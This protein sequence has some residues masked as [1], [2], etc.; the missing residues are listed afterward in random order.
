MSFQDSASYRSSTLE[1]I[2]NDCSI[3]EGETEFNVCS[4]ALP[5]L[6][7]GETENQVTPDLPRPQPTS[8]CETTPA[9]QLTLATAP[10]ETDSRAENPLTSQQMEVQDMFFPLRPLVPDS[11]GP[12]FEDNWAKAFG[13]SF[14]HGGD[15]TKVT[16]HYPPPSHSFL[17]VMGWGPVTDQV[18]RLLR[19]QPD[20]YGKLKNLRDKDL[21]AAHSNLIAAMGPILE[22]TVLLGGAT[23]PP[24][25]A[26]VQSLSATGFT[27]GKAAFDLVRT[28][29]KNILD[30]FPWKAVASSEWKELADN[31]A[32]SPATGNDLFTKEMLEKIVDFVKTLVEHKKRDSEL[33]RLLPSSYSSGKQ[34]RVRP[35]STRGAHKRPPTSP[36]TQ[37][38]KKPRRAPPQH[39]KP[40]QGR[41][42]DA[43]SSKKR[44]S[45]RD[46]SGPANRCVKGVYT[47]LAT[48][49]NRPGGT[50]Q[51][52]IRTETAFL[53]N[54]DKT[55]RLATQ[56]HTDKLGSRG[57]QA[58]RRVH[59]FGSSCG[60][61]IQKKPVHFS[62][63]PDGKKPSRL[64][65]HPKPKKVERLST[66]PKVQNGKLC[67]SSRPHPSGLLDG[68]I[69]SKRRLL[70]RENISGPS[71]VPVLRLEGKVLLLP[72]HAK[73]PKSGSTRVHENPKAGHGIYKST[74]HKSLYLSG[75]LPP[76]R[77]QL[78]EPIGGLGVYKVPIDRPGFHHKRQKILK[79]PDSKT[80]IFGFRDRLQ[81]SDLVSPTRQTPG[82]PRD[83]P[84]PPSG[85]HTGVGKTAGPPD[86]VI[87][88]GGSGYTDRK[89]PLQ[90]NAAAKTYGINVQK[91]LHS[92]H[93]APHH[94][95]GGATVVGKI[96]SRRKTRAD[97][98]RS[99]CPY[100]YLYRQLTVYVGRFLKRRRHSRHLDSKGDSSPHK[101]ARNSS[102]PKSVEP[103][104][105]EYTGSIPGSV[106]RQQNG[107]SLHS[108]NGG[109]EKHSTQPDLPRNMEGSSETRLIPDSK[110]HSVR[111]K[112]GGRPVVSQTAPKEG[113]V[114]EHRGIQII[115]QTLGHPRGRFVCDQHQRESVQV[116]V[117]GTRPEGHGTERSGGGN[118]VASGQDCICIP[119][120]PTSIEDSSKTRPVESRKPHSD[121]T[122]VENTD[123]LP[124]N[125]GAAGRLPA[126]SP[127]SEQH[128]SRPGGE[129]SPAA[130]SR[131]PELE[132]LEGFLQQVRAEGFSIKATEY[133]RLK[134]RA[135]SRK[136]YQNF[137]RPWSSWCNSRKI[138]PF[139]AN[140]QQLAEYLVYLFHDRE[141]ATSSIGVA[142]SAISNFAKPFEGSPL[143][144][145]K[146]ICQLIKA[147][148]NNRPP[149]ARYSATW[150]IDSLLC[151]WDSQPENSVLTLKLL[152]LKATALIST[153]TLSRADE[154][155][156]VL[157][158]NYAEVETGLSFR[159]AKA[160][161][162]HKQGPIPDIYV[163]R[164]PDRPNA[165]PVICI[166]EYLNRTEQFRNQDDGLNRAN[167]FLSLDSRHCNVKVGSISRWLQMGMELAGIDTSTF[168][169]HSIRG[170]AVSSLAQKGL[171]IK[172]IMNKGRW[173]SSSV[174][175]NFYLREL[176]R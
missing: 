140:P 70:Q 127:S 50:E 23:R 145:H 139:S 169:A 149:K 39:K 68:Q 61:G 49:N 16:D 87:A 134:W 159:L 158:D 79:N 31:I 142:R 63:F 47:Y 90:S 97:C 171:S 154:I 71:K 92:S 41:G 67:S 102:S 74:G 162:N 27:L 129:P 136:T 17:K 151:Y 75:R 99:A 25:T 62:D 122:G 106:D 143:G 11:A 36:P 123:V 115:N 21:Q 103:L 77:R 104:H 32:R 1:D 89:T 40:F 144:E 164:V 117:L 168:K 170:A 114:S 110:I 38:W 130:T 105:P 174:L 113:V 58:N 85:G 95:P 18:T 157:K 35:A 59:L 20:T 76:S 93:V 124:L 29:R 132:G 55:D 147:F 78:P 45:T 66:S 73:W 165:C 84:K 19:V 4:P 69:G 150:S 156:H 6:P 14:I 3:L 88:G 135:G 175:K 141:L 96:P 22:L 10:Q 81:A 7:G 148:K 52:P 26:E 98:A 28:R 5:D 163:D 172:Q 43:A 48:V 116:H 86:R 9:L 53:Q 56:P 15:L 30:C 57:K 118:G 60:D 101:R 13:S 111:G 107:P 167:L 8:T 44:P 24:V 51:G 112:Q 155:C 94:S 161:K 33:A 80:G 37:A 146:R 138:D 42:K 109:H 83:V 65:V 153:S 121:S 82:N 108:E 120:N 34:K 100:R 12:R 126:D 125:S 137:W 119:S 54:P 131:Q 72:G 64:Q 133:I 166:L 176:P 128:S 160:P 91:E 152:T 2:I 46:E 173:R